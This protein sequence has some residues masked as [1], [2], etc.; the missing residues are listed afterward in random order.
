MA[1]AE[2]EDTLMTEAEKE[3]TLMEAAEKEDTL[4][5]ENMCATANYGQGSSGSSV[6]LKEKAAVFGEVVPE[7]QTVI[8]YKAMILEA[9]SYLDK[10]NGAD[11]D[12]LVDYVETKYG[13]LENL[14]ELL[15]SELNEL[16]LQSKIE[17]V[18]HV[19][20]IKVNVGTQTPVTKRK[21]VMQRKLQDAAEE[22][23]RLIAEAETKEKEAENAVRYAEMLSQVADDASV[24]VRVFE[25]LL[26][27]Y[28]QDD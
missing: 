4:M 14:R 18:A 21:D 17:Q 12:T 9:L 11:F 23:A 19:Y 5:T 3:D 27:E 2:K 25:E 26:A 24:T 7:S 20:R 22:A 28:P 15:S 16:I 6:P 10:H 13:T 8:G 1:E